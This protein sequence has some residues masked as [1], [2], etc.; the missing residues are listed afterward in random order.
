[1]FILGVTGGIGCGK[2]T[3]AALLKEAGLAVLDA[4]VIS[5]ELTAPQGK[6]LPTI[7]EAFGPDILAEDGSLSRQEMARLV[8]QDKKQLDRLSGII[9]RDVLEE[10]GLRLDQLSEK[11]VQAVALDV[12]L[13][14]KHGF[15]D[16]CD[17]VWCV[18]ADEK[19]RLNRLLLRGLSQEEAELRIRVQ[20]TEEEYRKLSTH[21]IFNNGDLSD[22][23]VKVQGLLE[24]ELQS[25]GIVYQS[26]C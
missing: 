23:R 24:S 2:S 21:M 13:P 20:L 9:H 25:R 6:S 19:I 1:M 17:Q 4:D 15:L 8:F 11:K 10:I 12:P 22:L 7:V 3:V 14:V 5:H 16:R 18:W 26:L